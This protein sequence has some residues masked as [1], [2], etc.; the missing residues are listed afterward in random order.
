M[1]VG[2]FCERFARLRA[3]RSCREAKARRGGETRGAGGLGESLGALPRGAATSDDAAP[4]GAHASSTADHARI[5]AAD[6]GGDMTDK[7]LLAVEDIPAV[8]AVGFGGLELGFVVG[9][10]IFVAELLAPAAVGGEG[11]DGEL[12]ADVGGDGLFYNLPSL[13]FSG[14]PRQKPHAAPLPHVPAAAAGLAA[15]SFVADVGDARL[16][17]LRTSRYSRPAG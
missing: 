5:L 17:S 14:P 8:A 15:R 1:V 9:L 13:F 16:V 11:D 4:S 2:K 12:D 6:Y 10:D 3:D 7:S